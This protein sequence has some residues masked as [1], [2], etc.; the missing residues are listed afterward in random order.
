MLFSIVYRA[1]SLG[2]Y[3]PMPKNK[4]LEC[5]VIKKAIGNLIKP[6]A[7]YLVLSPYALYRDRLLLIR[8]IIRVAKSLILISWRM[9]RPGRPYLKLRSFHKWP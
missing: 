6:D 7:S 4:A 2:C 5:D 1:S 3:C 9:R 8:L